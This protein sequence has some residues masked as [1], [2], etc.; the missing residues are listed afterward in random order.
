MNIFIFILPSKQWRWASIIK[1][2]LAGDYK[3]TIDMS[4]VDGRRYNKMVARV[5]KGPPS[6]AGSIKTTFHRRVEH[7]H[8]CPTFKVTHISIDKIVDGNIQ[9]WRGGGKK[10]RIWFSLSLSHT[11]THTLTYIYTHAHTHTH[12][13]TPTWKHTQTCIPRNTKKISLWAM[14]HIT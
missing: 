9:Q 5:G 6:P 13:H 12:S 7:R 4:C 11:N 3:D 14:Q 1:T 8:R 2:T 10:G